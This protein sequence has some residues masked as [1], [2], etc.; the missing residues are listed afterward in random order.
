M[1]PINKRR[2]KP[3]DKNETI[4]EEEARLKLE[5]KEIAKNFKHVKPIKYLLK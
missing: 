3:L 2:K 1:T 5:A 4:F